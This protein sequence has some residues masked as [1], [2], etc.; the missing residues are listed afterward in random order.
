MAMAAPLGFGV[1]HDARLANEEYREKSAAHRYRVR[2]R[3]GRLFKRFLDY[4]RIDK[5]PYVDCCYWSPRVI[6]LSD[7]A[8]FGPEPKKFRRSLMKTP[9]IKRLRPYSRLSP[10]L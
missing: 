1:R 10:A 6:V 3:Y 8:R 7:G 2:C 9:S 5:T 4:V